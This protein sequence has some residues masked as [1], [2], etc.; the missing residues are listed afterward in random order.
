[1][2]WFVA[3]I[4]RMPNEFDGVIQIWI[5][6]DHIGETVVSNNMLMV[7]GEGCAEKQRCLCQQ[8]ID[9]RI[10]RD[11]K[12]A[13]IMEYIYRKQPQSSGEC[14]NRKITSADQIIVLCNRQKE[15]KCH[16]DDLDHRYLC[17]VATI[18]PRLI[19]S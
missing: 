13:A 18:E 11:R 7:P 3:N 12:V 8:V 1:M 6:S 10:S 15:K 19:R 17:P 2:W 16:F 5:L 14:D 9:N 4:F